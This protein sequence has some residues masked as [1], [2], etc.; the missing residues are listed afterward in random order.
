MT[1]RLSSYFAILLLVLSWSAFAG[2]IPDY[3]RGDWNHWIDRDGDCLDTRHE[4]LLRESLTS[5]TFKQNNNCKVVGGRWP[6][7][8]PVPG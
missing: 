3:N 2:A 1:L 6:V 4:L 8:R 7:V 5:V